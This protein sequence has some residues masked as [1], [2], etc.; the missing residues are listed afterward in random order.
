MDRRSK[1]VH[2]ETICTEKS[3]GGIWKK[4][5]RSL[6]LKTQTQHSCCTQGWVSF[7]SYPYFSGSSFIATSSTG[8][9]SARTYFSWWNYFWLN[10]H[11]GKGERF[12]ITGEKIHGQG[13]ILAVLKKQ[14]KHPKSQTPHI[15]TWNEWAIKPKLRRRKIYPQEIFST[16]GK[17]WL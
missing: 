13:L 4:G 1:K 9:L 10:Y 12:K 16:D 8:F 15:S 6:V 14:T 3:S 2:E 17:I 5:D 11:R 7:P